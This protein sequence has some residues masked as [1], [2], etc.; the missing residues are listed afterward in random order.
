M[1]ET[2]QITIEDKSYPFKVAD[3]VDAANFMKRLP[4]T[5]RFEDFGRN[6]R[7]AYPSP[8]INAVGEPQAFDITPG[9]VAVY[10]PWGNIAVFR[11]TYPWD[12]NLQLL[13][14]VDEATLKAIVESG[15]KPVVISR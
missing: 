15:D 7:V 6:E 8:R 11:V 4:V 5:V 9:T 1:A 14:R 3:N 12:E 2:V 13:G 10:R